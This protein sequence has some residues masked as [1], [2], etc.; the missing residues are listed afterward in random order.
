MSPLSDEHAGRSRMWSG[1][2][3]SRTRPIC[4][5]RRGHLDR[6]R[7]PSER[8][9]SGRRS[10]SGG[11]V[12][13][14]TS[15]GG[16]DVRSDGAAPL[17][18]GR[19]ALAPT[20]PAL[21]RAGAPAWTAGTLRGLRRGRRGAVGSDVDRE[22]AGSGVDGG[23]WGLRT[24]PLGRSGERAGSREGVAGG[25]EDD[26]RPRG[27]LNS[28]ARARGAAR[29]RGG[30]VHLELQAHIPIHHGRTAPK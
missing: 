21:A 28:R 24:Q 27:W 14:R 15:R 30:L 22:G 12:T 6:H 26:L 20:L 7:S 29:S 1:A 8:V 5:F 10:A 11:A 16:G 19:E 18:L 3:S 17:V 4:S 13:G 25:L 2:R 9:T 23:R